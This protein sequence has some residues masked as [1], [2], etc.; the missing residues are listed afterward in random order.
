ML[1]LI[2]TLA[3]W[4]FAGIILIGP[5]LAVLAIAA[6]LIVAVVATIAPFVV[7]GLFFY[8]PYRLLF[9]RGQ[10]V[11]RAGT[12]CQSE[13]VPPA[14]WCAGKV[15]ETADWS[16]RV[17]SRTAATGWIALETICGA[18]IG[19]GMGWLL[20]SPLMKKRELVLYV[21][22]ACLAGAVLGLL[23]GL[24]NHFGTL[25]SQTSSS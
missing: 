16:G 24:A 25:R 23:V 15:R 8:L 5:A 22:L 11:R 6:S 10:P 20:A 19:S 3:A 18:L 12:A 14:R 21:L 4:G 7:L 2:V 1:R 9:V 13:V 17:C